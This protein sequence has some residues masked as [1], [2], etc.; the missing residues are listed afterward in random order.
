MLLLLLLLLLYF[1]HDDFPCIRG[2]LRHLGGTDRQLAQVELALGP[3]ARI[4][5]ELGARLRRRTPQRPSTALPCR[6]VTS[7]C[8]ICEFS[9]NCVLTRAFVCVCVKIPVFARVPL[10]SRHSSS[11]SSRMQSRR[12]WAVLLRVLGRLHLVSCETL[13]SELPSVCDGTFQ[14]HLLCAHATC[15][16]TPSSAIILHIIDDTR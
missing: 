1:A 8:C 2:R 6:S 4:W 13:C 12:Q 11:D 14:G 15:V 10:V 3:S 5:R 9:P 16:D 7:M